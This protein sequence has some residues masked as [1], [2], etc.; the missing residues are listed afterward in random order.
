MGS[1]HRRESLRRGTR[2][3]TKFAVILASVSLLAGCSEPVVNAK[4]DISNATSS[5]TA[6]QDHAT[7]TNVEFKQAKSKLL[8]KC[9]EFDKTCSFTWPQEV[10]AQ[11]SKVGT[12]EG[13]IQLVVFPSASGAATDLLLSTSYMGDDWIFFDSLQIKANNETTTFDFEPSDL[14]QDVFDGGTVW[15]YGSKYV[16]TDQ[17]ILLLKFATSRVPRFR[18]IGTQGSFTAS[19]TA[20][21]SEL[22]RASLEVYFGLRE[23]LH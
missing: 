20:R 15:E 2:L 18:L 10:S 13:G 17:A 5:P 7:V 12:S 1:L 8:Y 22:M 21:A 16:D 11:D 19:Q 3:I 4:K 14:S 9:D 6:Q 23:G